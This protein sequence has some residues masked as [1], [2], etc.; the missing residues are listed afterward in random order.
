MP[1][2]PIL[3]TLLGQTCKATAET[4]II[5][6]GHLT[7]WP[8]TSQANLNM[9]CN[10]P[11]QSLLFSHS[12]TIYQEPVPWKVLYLSLDRHWTSRNLRFK[13]RRHTWNYHIKINHT[14]NIVKDSHRKTH[15]L[16]QKLAEVEE[17]IGEDLW[18]GKTVESN[19]RTS[20]GVFQ[21]CPEEL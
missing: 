10:L 7:C 2:I 15:E 16:G 11:K 9:N 21:V 4:I 19:M 5:C 17:I 13:H 6:Q 18:F 3:D 14:I 1:A 20:N 8:W 12:P